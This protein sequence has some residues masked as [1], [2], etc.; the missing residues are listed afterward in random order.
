[1]A[2]LNITV[3]NALP[4]TLEPKTMYLVASATPGLFDIVV[5]TKDGLSSKTLLTEQMVD[6]KITDAI[7]SITG[8]NSIQV[9]ADIAAR[10]ALSLNDAPTIVWVIDASADTTVTSGAASYIWDGG[11]FYKLTE[12]E[13]MDVVLDWANIQNG[14]SST[15]EDIDSAVSFAHAHEN[16]GVLNSLG[17]SDGYLTYNGSLI[18]ETNT[19]DATDPE[20]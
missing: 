10:D 14:P 6:T 13:S 12:F 11:A 19:V 3:V 4:A 18:G 7:S 2:N 1:M 5:S 9:V 17:E 8:N 15:P 20:W 16:A